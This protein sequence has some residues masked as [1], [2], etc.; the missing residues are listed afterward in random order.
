M[1]FAEKEKTMI[2]FVLRDRPHLN[3]IFNFQ[4]SI[5]LKVR[6]FDKNLFIVW[7]KLKSRYEIHS[8]KSYLPRFKQWTTHQFD[9]FDPLD[10][11]LLHYLYNNSLRHRGN[12]IFEILEYENDLMMKEKKDR[13]IRKVRNSINEVMRTVKGYNTSY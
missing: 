3:P 13:E 4:N 7:N 5:V 8:L 12:E 1:I 11:R 6:E 9:W 2:R 10:D